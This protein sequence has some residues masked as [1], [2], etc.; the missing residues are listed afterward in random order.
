MKATIIILKASHLAPEWPWGRSLLDA[1]PTNLLVLN[2][3]HT[4]PWTALQ[5]NCWPLKQIKIDLCR[6]QNALK[7]PS[8]AVFPLF[9]QKNEKWISSLPGRTWTNQVAV[10]LWGAGGKWW[11]KACPRLSFSATSYLLAGTREMPMLSMGGNLSLAGCHSYWLLEHHSRP[12]HRVL[13]LCVAGT[14]VFPVLS[15]RLP[16]L[17]SHLCTSHLLNFFLPPPRWLLNTFCLFW[18]YGDVTV[19]FSSAGRGSPSSSTAPW[20]FQLHIV[21]A[22]IPKELCF[23]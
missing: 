23:W 15:Y 8:P 10:R 14:E 13:E 21:Q 9:L 17:Q 2:P 22:T 6:L 7:I 19:V 1:F 16:V 11:T 18:H 12:L 3:V 20:I 4:I 5:W